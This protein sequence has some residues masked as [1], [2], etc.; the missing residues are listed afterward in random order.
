MPDLATLIVFCLAVLALLATPGPDMLYV[1]ARSAGQGR[2][3][4]MVSVLGLCAGDLVHIFAAA[5]GLS[6]LLMTSAL[7][8]KIIKY[9]GAAY[10]VYLGLRMLISREERAEFQASSGDNFLKIFAQGALSSMLNPKV[11]LFFLSFLPQFIDPAKGQVL[12]QIIALSF[13]WLLISLLAYTSLAMVAGTFSH[14]LRGRS[15]FARFQKWLTGSI[16]VGLGFRLA[17]PE[18]R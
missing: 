17:L 1:I 10:L 18:Q 14:W 2:M 13:A 5:V 9:V 15:S 16:L 4:G 7:A 8:Y 6:T 3:A 11:A 12:G